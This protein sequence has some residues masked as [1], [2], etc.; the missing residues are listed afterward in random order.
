MLNSNKTVKEQETQAFLELF[1]ALRVKDQK[2]ADLE[3]SLRAAND[4]VHSLESQ[5][6]GGSVK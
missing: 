2:I 5:V 1:E 6:Y 4:R 3:K